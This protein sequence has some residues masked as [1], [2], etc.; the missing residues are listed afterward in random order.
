MRSAPKFQPLLT[1]IRA[2]CRHIQR[3]TCDSPSFSMR[4][5]DSFS[6]IPF[7]RHPSVEKRRG[8]ARPRRILEGAHSGRGEVIRTQA[9]DE[10][11]LMAVGARQAAHPANGT[12][13]FDNSNQ[14]TPVPATNAT[15]STIS[16]T[17]NSTHACQRH[18]FEF[19]LNKFYHTRSPQIPPCL[20][21]LPT[22]RIVR[23]RLHQSPQTLTVPINATNPTNRTN[24]TT[25]II[26]N[27]TVPINATSSSNEHHKHDDPGQRY[28]SHHQRNQPVPTGG[29]GRRAVSRR[30]TSIVGV[31][32]HEDFKRRLRA[33]I[34]EEKRSPASPSE[35]RR[36]PR[37]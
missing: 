36:A 7:W 26:T 21:T 22:P 20:S 33:I 19:Q 14:T 18:Q 32:A 31:D 6:L 30:W 12:K 34:A 8:H 24:S 25:P 27:S 29:M 28:H 17:T 2:D 1:P 23:T 3:T 4:F 37:R 10:Q 16:R 15:N 35:V 5:S 13:P 9:F 11:L